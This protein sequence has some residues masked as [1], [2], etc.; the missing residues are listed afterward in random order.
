MA[1]KTLHFGSLSI[2]LD[3]PAGKLLSGTREPLAAP[4]PD[5]RAA[6]ADALE[7]PLEFPALRRALTPDDHLAILV[8]EEMSSLGEALEAILLH[9]RSAG[10]KPEQVTVLVPPRSAGVDTTWSSVLPAGV[11]GFR[12]EE[13]QS[14]A[15]HLAYL[16][17]T[18]AG[19]RVYLNRTL[20][21]ADQLIIL[22]PARFDPLFVVSSGL[23]DLFPTFSDEPTRQEL[24]RQL[25]TLLT[26]RTKAPAV[27]AEAEAVGWLLGLPFVVTLIEGPGQSVTHVVAGAA[28]A[29]RARAETIQREQ[30]TLTVDRQVD[31]AVGTIASNRN[32]Q[33]FTDVATAALRLS[34]VVR[35]GGAMALLT[36]A[37]PDLPAGAD[38]M[39]G[40]EDAVAGLARVRREAKV[41]SVP[42]WHLTTALGQAKLYLYSRI[43]AE[44]VEEM[45][46]T[47]LEK[48]EQVQQL[49]GN[50]ES[51][52]VV[53]D[54][55][56]TLIEVRREPSK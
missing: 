34:R 45:F 31:L 44:A 49:I 43:P 37:R 30:H 18:E 22:G 12:V 23:A 4:L 46:V 16:A 27:W 42:W 25:H 11:Q 20:V 41:D 28:A 47:P 40:A 51:V 13:H 14:S 2:A 29:V 39:R 32:R 19:R 33:S 9:V 56:R 36:D 21:D 6:V 3:V 55:D 50:A 54:A 5:V 35:Q 15:D 10:V 7:T 17:S 48:P 24:Q 38:L 1:T 52:L 8:Q 26:A 53:E